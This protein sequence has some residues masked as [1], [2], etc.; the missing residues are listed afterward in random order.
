MNDQTTEYASA[1]DNRS[2]LSVSVLADKGVFVP[3][4]LTG[5]LLLLFAGLTAA[6]FQGYLRDFD[7]HWLQGLRRPDQP[8]EPIGPD[9]G[10]R[11]VRAISFAGNYHVLLPAIPVVAGLW[12]LFR[13]WAAGIYLLAV[14]GTS[15]GLNVLIKYT[16][17]RARPPWA[18]RLVDQD[19]PGYPSAHAMVNTTA[20]LAIALLLA[21]QASSRKVRAAILAVGM[22]GPVAIGTSRIYLG[23]HWATDVLGGWALGIAWALMG[24][25]VLELC[26]RRSCTPDS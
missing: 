25:L 12:M 6:V 22:L 17:D 3:A 23:V 4:T 1:P 7:L 15:F 9:W 16:T 26:V 14:T 11:I 13:K 10:A 19:G 5:V 24:W 18:Y 8:R 20:W 2:P 21:R